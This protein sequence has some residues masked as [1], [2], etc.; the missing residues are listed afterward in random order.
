M[1]EIPIG[2]QDIFNFEHG[3][4]TT[5]EITFGPYR[6]HIDKNPARD[7]AFVRGVK[8][9]YSTEIDECGEIQNIVTTSPASPGSWSPTAAVEEHQSLGLASVLFPD[10]PVMKVVALPLQVR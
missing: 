6:I 3:I 10:I 5:R 4:S 7:E 9:T 1:D 8:T 2:L